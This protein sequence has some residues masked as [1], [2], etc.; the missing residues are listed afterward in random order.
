[1][2]EIPQWMFDAAVVCLIRCEVSARTSTKALSELKELIS[3]GDR[4]SGSDMVQVHQQ[5]RSCRG[6]SDAPRHEV[7][8]AVES[9]AA[10][11][12]TPQQAPVGKPTGRGAPGG[13]RAA[14]AMA[15]RPRPR[16]RTVRERG[17]AR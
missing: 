6:G 12:P 2:L 13:A 1:M 14:R 8:P 5:S 10:V 9:I 4:A 3:A 16:R 7:V 17:G 15:A 11:P